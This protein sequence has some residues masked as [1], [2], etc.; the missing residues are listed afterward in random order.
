VRTLW[1][2]DGIKSEQ[3]KVEKNGDR[4]RAKTYVR[5]LSQT[6]V[7]AQIQA[8]R[9]LI[10]VSAALRDLVENIIKKR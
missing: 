7:D 2:M 4:F 8:S 1:R 5:I 3:P 10:G 9:E 6:H